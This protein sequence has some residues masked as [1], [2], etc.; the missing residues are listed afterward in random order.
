[1]LI[2]LI[3]NTLSLCK[4]VITRERVTKDRVEKAVI[5][6]VIVCDTLWHFSIL[7]KP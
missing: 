6:Y 3:V 2:C 5:D 1:M 7:I 4:G